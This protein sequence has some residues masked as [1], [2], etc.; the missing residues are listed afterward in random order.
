MIVLMNKKIAIVQSCYIPWK[1]YFDIIAA[2]DE[3]ILY[4][5]MQ[6]TKNDWR[7]RNK[8]KTRNGLEWLTIPVGQNISRRIRDVRVPEGRYLVKHWKSITQNYCR[9]RYFH[10]IAAWLEPL[11]LLNKYQYLSDLNRVFIQA[12]CSYLNI[13]TRI[14]G[15]WDFELIEGKTERL[16]DLCEKTGGVEYISGLSAKNYIDEALFSDRKIKLTWF[17][18]SEYLEYPQLWGDFVHEVTVLDLL[19]NC[20]KDAGRYLLCNNR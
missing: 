6:Y 3:F 12:I 4:D 15:S 14:S 5:D 11:Y 7:N 16:V 9:A 2:V 8:I 13:T 19:F 20:G 10:E 17:D 18:Y 1:G